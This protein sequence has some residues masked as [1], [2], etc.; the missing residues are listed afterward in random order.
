[1]ARRWGTQKNRPTMNYD[2]LSRSLR[3]YYEKGIMQKVSRE[4]YVYRFINYAEI[5][6]FNPALFETT[7]KELFITSL[8]HNTSNV[9]LNPATACDQQRRQPTLSVQTSQ[10]E[11]IKKEPR[12]KSISNTS[13][14]KS[15]TGSKRYLPYAK[16]ASHVYTKQEQS[17]QHSQPHSPHSFQEQASFSNNT[18]LSSG[19][20][21]SPS[22]VQSGSSAYPATVS[23]SHNIDSPKSNENNSFYFN[24]QPA[25]ST[26]TTNAVSSSSTNSTTSYYNNYSNNSQNYHSGSSGNQFDQYSNFHYPCYS[27]A[28]PYS[29]KQQ[30]QQQQQQ[31]LMYNHESANQSYASQQS[32]N[33]FSPYST[34]QWA[35]SKYNSYVPYYANH[36]DSPQFKELFA[37]QNNNN[38]TTTTTTSLSPFSESSSFCSNTSY[39]Y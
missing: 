7:N 24:G 3:Y 23:V 9:L 32:S 2:K 35:V 1:M 12:L 37:S 19:Y 13:S 29:N 18:T 4:R 38:S 20:S 17:I 39:Q 5:C 14:S 8:A 26:P 16:P 33:Y 21:S 22:F 36:Y 30:H 34:P 27:H 6:Q 28:S 31:Q 11:A 10:S 25:S 15:S